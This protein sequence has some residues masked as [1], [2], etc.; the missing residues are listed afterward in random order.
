MK[1]KLTI[2][3]VVLCAGI[4]TGCP[5]ARPVQ[6][7]QLNIPEQSGTPAASS[8]PVTLLVGPITSSHLYREDPIVYSTSGESMGTY[9]Y[10]RWAAPP[11]E[12]IESVLRQT[13]RISGKYRGVY[14]MRSN[15]RGDYMLRGQL[16]DF[17][18][19][20]G[21]S[22]VARL[23]LE[24]EMRDMKNGTV[25]WSHDYMHD[26]PVSVKDVSAVVDALDKNVQRAAAEIKASLEEY[27]AAHP[28]AKSTSPQ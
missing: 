5:A 23:T 9:Q 14:A 12:M 20:S 10:H 16:I 2:A 25:V 27:F 11:T 8:I 22:V 6:Y 15:S 28:P 13:L 24:L 4:A 21:S 26:E 19:V 7:Y 3:A 18:E 1:N 17:K